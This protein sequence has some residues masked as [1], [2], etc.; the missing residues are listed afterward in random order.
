[1][2]FK[3]F[4]SYHWEQSFPILRFCFLP[5]LW[6]LSWVYSVRPQSN[7]SLFSQEGLG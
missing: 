2:F 7:Q 3:I 5:S 4:Q 6:M 1:M